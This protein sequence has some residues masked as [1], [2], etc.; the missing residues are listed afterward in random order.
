MGVGLGIGKNVRTCLGLGKN[1]FSW[2]RYTEFRYVSEIGSSDENNVLTA[3]YKTPSGS[4]LSGTG[5][6]IM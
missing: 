3:K 5:S 4:I 1:V 6:N 2:G